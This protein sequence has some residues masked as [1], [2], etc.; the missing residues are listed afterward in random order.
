MIGPVILWLFR[1]C[2]DLA[3][4]RLRM[5]IASCS[6]KMAS[7]AYISRHRL[8]SLLS[9]AIATTPAEV[10]M[11]NKMSAAGTMDELGNPSDEVTREAPRIA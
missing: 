9:A 11:P 1:S 7:A 4:C 8:A 5:L 10:V 2:R 3:L 6:R